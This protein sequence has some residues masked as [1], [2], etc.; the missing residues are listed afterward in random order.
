MM[1]PFH[2]RVFDCVYLMLLADGA[3][4]VGARFLRANIGNVTMLSRWLTAAI[5]LSAIF[6][7]LAAIVAIAKLQK[8]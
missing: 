7:Q 5:I 8:I 1:I 2:P 4:Y 3:I 6:A